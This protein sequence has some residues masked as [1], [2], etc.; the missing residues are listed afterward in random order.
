MTVDDLDIRALHRLDAAN[1]RLRHSVVEACFYNLRML[2]QELPGRRAANS[3]FL[4]NLTEALAKVADARCLIDGYFAHE[5]APNVSIRSLFPSESHAVSQSLVDVESCYQSGVPSRDD[6]PACQSFAERVVGD[7]DDILG[8]VDHIREATRRRR[9]PV[10]EVLEALCSIHRAACEAEG[11]A[12]VLQPEGEDEMLVF[13]D[14]AALLDALGELLRNALKYAFPACHRGEKQIT[15]RAEADDET[16][17]TVIVISDTGCGMSTER[18]EKVGAAGAST[19]GSGDGIAMVRRIIEDEHFGLVTYQSELERGTTVQVRLPRRAEPPLEP[20][21]GDGAPGASGC[22]ADRLPGR[23]RQF[24]AAGVF[25]L[26]LS[27]GLW[28]AWLTLAS[29]ANLTVAADGSGDYLRIADAVAAARPDA[30]IR[31]QPGVYH[32]HLI[33]DKPVRIIGQGRR[34]AV[35]RATQSCAVFSTA[36][37]AELRNLSILLD[38]NA[39]F[40]A[41]LIGGGNLRVEDCQISSRGL[42]CIEV[43]AGSPTVKNNLIHNGARSGIFV[44]G[45]GAGLYEGNTIRDCAGWGVV[46]SDAA[47]PTVRGNTITGCV[48]GEMKGNL[49]AEDY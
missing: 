3:G 5:V 48:Q 21:P 34:E 20:A 32:E 45:T 28:L 7:V 36:T 23:R 22:E 10:N 44:H 42:S 9:L 24:A 8:S 29:Q 27:A 1:S 18:L 25:V 33:L 6:A 26:I 37:G 46:V 2:V 19:S 31:V 39:E 17:D 13:A 11:I 16:R 35:I 15:L 30:T 47:R 12:L 40:A 41:V 49:G 43:A 14:R 4:Q 38:A